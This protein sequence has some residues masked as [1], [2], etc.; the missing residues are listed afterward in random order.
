MHSIRT[1]YYLRQFALRR[2]GPLESL[3]ISRAF[4]FLPILFSDFL[5]RSFSFPLPLLQSISLWANLSLSPLSFSLLSLPRHLKDF[6][7]K[8]L[9]FTGHSFHIWSWILRDCQMRPFGWCWWT[10]ISLPLSGSYDSSLDNW[11]LDESLQSSRVPKNS[12]S[13]IS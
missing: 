10:K 13:I 8:F 4:P 7:M 2:H 11:T 6:L 9:Q 1:K 12:P 3:E 5:Q